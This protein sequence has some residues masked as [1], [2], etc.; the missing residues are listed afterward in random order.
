VDGDEGDLYFRF[1][2]NAKIYVVGFKLPT[3]PL[4]ASLRFILSLGY[5]VC[6]IMSNDCF[7][8]NNLQILINSSKLRLR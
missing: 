2:K 3:L 6:M 8:G 1:A 7:L 4:A 5:A